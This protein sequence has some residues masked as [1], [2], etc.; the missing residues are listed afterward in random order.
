[1]DSGNRNRYKPIRPGWIQIS[2]NLSPVLWLSVS[3][4]P[5]DNSHAFLY[6]YSHGCIIFGT[7][8]F[9]IS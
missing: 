3:E 5:K 1:V 8:I 7:F 4:V 2:Y 6:L 9:L